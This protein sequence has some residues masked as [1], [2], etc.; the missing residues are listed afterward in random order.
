MTHDEAFLEALREHPEDDAPRL[1][2]ADWLDEH[3]D[4]ARAE[5]IRLQCELARRPMDDAR[6][7][8]L[9]LRA[10]QHLHENRERWD[11]FFDR[12]Y[13]VGVQFRRGF[14]ELLAL[15]G[16]RSRQSLVKRARRMRGL[17]IPPPSA[18]SLPWD[19]AR[20]LF[21]AVRKLFEGKA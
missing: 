6:Y 16:Q 5:F 15:K 14:I 3:G 11:P 4:P 17:L 21:V 2:Y 19:F 20:V 7:R 10:E 9:D 18:H 13:H 1:I 8:I 12:P